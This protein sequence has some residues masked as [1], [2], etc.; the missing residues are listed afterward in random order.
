MKAA[1]LC[2]VFFTV[3]ATTSSQPTCDLE[4]VDVCQQQDLQTLQHQLTVMKNEILQLKEQVDNLQMHGR[5]TLNG[6]T[7]PSSDLP[8][9]TSGY[10]VRYSHLVNLY[11]AGGNR[12]AYNDFRRVNITCF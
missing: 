6:T 5:N 7:L 9:S 1:V 11:L 8:R 10:I 3:V 2:A 12:L 4:C